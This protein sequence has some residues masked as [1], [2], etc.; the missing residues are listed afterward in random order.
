MLPKQSG[1]AHWGLLAKREPPIHLRGVAKEASHFPVFMRP[2]GVTSVQRQY[3][4]E[5]E[6]PADEQSGTAGSLQQVSQRNERFF[7][8]EGEA[9]EEKEVV[10]KVFF[11]FFFFFYLWNFLK[12]FSSGCGQRKWRHSSFQFH[13]GYLKRPPSLKLV[14]KHAGSQVV[15]GR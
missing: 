5:A 8:L 13:S 1:K 14:H 12:N 10:G 2:G 6:R 7:F 15:E 4:S 11:S 9:S 3:P